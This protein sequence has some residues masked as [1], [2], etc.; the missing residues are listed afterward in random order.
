MVPVGQL[1][2][3]VILLVSDMSGDSII[4]NAPGFQPGDGRSSPPSRSNLLNS[5]SAIDS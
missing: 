5:I 1:K 2:L 3:Y 4:G